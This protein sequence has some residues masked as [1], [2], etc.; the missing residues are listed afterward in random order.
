MFVRHS[1]IPLFLAVCEE[2]NTSDW[3]LLVCHTRMLDKTKEQ[4][5]ILVS[6]W[7]ATAGAH[8]RTETIYIN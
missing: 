6:S 5:K 7:T 2:W 8:R 1:E 4:D 3:V